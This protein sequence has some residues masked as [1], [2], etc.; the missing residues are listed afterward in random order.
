MKGFK[1][2]KSTILKMSHDQKIQRFR[3][4]MEIVE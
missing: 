2:I 3:Y 4:M 1:G